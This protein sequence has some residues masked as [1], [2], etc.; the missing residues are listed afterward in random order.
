M[1]KME[2]SPFVFKTGAE[3]ATATY[4]GDCITVTA[5]AVKQLSVLSTKAEL[6]PCG[7]I[8]TFATTDCRPLS[9]RA[10]THVDVTQPFCEVVWTSVDG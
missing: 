10:I 3:E 4:S 1:R 7:A 2:K 6:L 8:I 5:A 9:P